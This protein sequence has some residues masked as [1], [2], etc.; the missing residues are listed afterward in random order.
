MAMDTAKLMGLMKQKKAAL[1]QKSK[2]L[3]PN[4]GANRYVLLPGWRKGEEHVY[5]HEFGQHYIKNSAGEIQA[6]YPCM[7]AIYGKACPVCEGISKAVRITSDDEVVKQLED[8]AC[9]MKKQV[10]LVNVLALDSDDP[11]T[12]QIL[13]VK[14]S[15]F[16][17]I[18]EIVEEWAAG[19]FD[20]ENP[21]ILVLNRDGKGLN[22]KYTVQ[23]SAK[24]S[25]M[26]DGVESKIHN[27]DEYVLQENEE[28]QRRALNAISNVAGLLPSGS[29]KPKTAAADNTF[30]DEQEAGLRSAERAESKAA[31]A[32]L[33]LDDELDDLLGEL[34]TGT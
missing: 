3:K 25:A 20:P 33:A 12:P 21:Q 9:G 29:D 11:K 30:D 22:T 8:A 10:Y 17:Q 5:F 26:P 28:N 4:P 7:D 19:V 18:V 23:I 14:K 6:V 34:G 31:K 13:E 27:L 32:D 24:R 1:K 2:T 16:G 15:A